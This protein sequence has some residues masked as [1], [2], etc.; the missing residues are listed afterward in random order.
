MNVR[1]NIKRIEEFSS[2]SFL[3]GV[4]TPLGVSPV[5]RDACFHLLARWATWLLAASHC[6]YHA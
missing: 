3:F 6:Q 4:C 1:Q 2:F 5:V